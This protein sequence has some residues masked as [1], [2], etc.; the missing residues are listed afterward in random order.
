MV[1]ALAC[2]YPPGY[3]SGDRMQTELKPVLS[4]QTTGK[5]TNL[6]P[7]LLYSFIPGLELYCV[8][9]VFKE[10][11]RTG[12]FT[13]L[14]IGWACHVCESGER[15]PT[16]TSAICASFGGC[17]PPTRGAAKCASLALMWGRGCPAGL[18]ISRATSELGL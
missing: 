7:Q 13:A 1:L 11:S 15:P 8:R 14:P 17:P 18:S 9:T 4:K 6:C 3:Y 2:D 10:N 12:Q 5:A 16:P